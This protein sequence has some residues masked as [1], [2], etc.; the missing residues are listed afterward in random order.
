M[1]SE[2]GRHLLRLLGEAGSRSA[3]PATPGTSAPN[4]ALPPRQVLAR[5]LGGSG[6][7]GNGHRPPQLPGEEIDDGL[8]L[9]ESVRSFRAPPLLHFDRPEFASVDSRAL[10]CFDTETTGLAGGAGTRAFLIGV[11]QIRE[12]ELVVR[13]LLLTRLGAETAMLRTFSGWLRSSQV[14]LSYNGK[15]FDTPLLRN[16]LRL[17]RLP[18]ALS[19]LAHL[20]LLHVVR[21]RFRKLWPNCRLK[22]AEQRVLGRV[23][24][25]D[26][27]GAAAPAAFVEFLRHGHSERLQGVVLHNREDLIGVTEL[28]VRLGSDPDPSPHSAVARALSGADPDTDAVAAVGPK[29]RKNSAGASAGEIR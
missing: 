9:I 24:G 20:D 26:L 23:R 14:L 17:A 3:V 4:P 5:R 7:G 8:R 15:S 2:I 21:R 16:R 18:N 11:A 1:S 29:R 19:G 13:Q 27:P 22:T 6:R 10:L 28:S 12:A 25:D